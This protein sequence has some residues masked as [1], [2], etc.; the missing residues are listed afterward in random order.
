[1]SKLPAFLTGRTRARAAPSRHRMVYSDVVIRTQ[2]H[3]GDE[4]LEL[5]DRVT[6]A[7]GASRSELIRRA[8]RSTFGETTKAERL[9]ALAA[10]AGSWRERT[11]TGTD[12]VD[13]A[14]GD[15]EQRLRRLGL[16]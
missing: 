7:T 5:L 4:E 6:R 9:R 10:S 8:V 16:D 2:V 15:L 3:L 14:R 11:V 1:M 13:A 12:F